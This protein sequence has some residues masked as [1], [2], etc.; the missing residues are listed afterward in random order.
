[1]KKIIFTL[2]ICSLFTVSN[3]RAQ[4]EIKIEREIPI[5]GQTKPIPI[6]LS[7][8]SGEAA[9]V[10]RLDLEVQGFKVVDGEP[11]QFQL[12][13]SNSGNVQ[14][15]L[16]DAIN[17]AELVAKA[18][19]GGTI[20]A[21]AHALA[22]DVVMAVLKNKGIGSTKIAFKVEFKG[23]AGRTS[24]IYISDFDGWNPTNATQDKSIVAA[25]DWVPGRMMIYYT[26]YK[27]G[28]PWIYRHNLSTG[29]RNPAAHFPGSNISP[30]V[31]PDG[32]R[33]A[34]VLDK[35][36]WIELYVSNIDGS[37]L[38][39]LT[40][41]RAGESSP[42][43]SP[44]GQWIAF[45]T[46]IGGRRSLAKVPFSG[47]ALQKIVTGGVSNPTEPDWSP[48]GKWIVFT[49]QMGGFELC[50]IP[51]AGGT[52][53]LLVSGEDPSFAPN[54]RTVIFARRSGNDRTL[55]LLDVFT[56]QSK[57]VRRISGSNSQPSWAK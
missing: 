37:G 8:F 14:G 30:A 31:S 46:E 1:M 22:D 44:D 29:D 20:R 25:P 3:S 12:S 32:K 16:T 48:D 6:S 2:L 4:N 18:Y 51:A 39:R 34:M 54:S 43:W 36:G 21:Q 41:S 38:T 33:V 40:T 23:D 5:L 13:G 28:K 50:V 26:S 57:D 15:R 49:A 9:S 52:A 19:T 45:A 7:G 24:E 55:S 47:G 53:T 42:C 35:D 10:L 56:K 11:P 27:S 17:K